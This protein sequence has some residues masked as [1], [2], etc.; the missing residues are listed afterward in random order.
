MIVVEK[1]WP[2]V[3]LPRVRAWWARV[4]AVNAVQLGIVILAGVT[5]DRW[6]GGAPP[7]HFRGR[8]A[9]PSPGS[10]RRRRPG[11]AGLPRLDVRLLLVAPAAPRVT[12]VLAALPP[13]IGRAHV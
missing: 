7:F 12:L 10:L 1:L 3:E 8:V 2:A 4:I 6:L 11:S 9:L 13:A 5:W